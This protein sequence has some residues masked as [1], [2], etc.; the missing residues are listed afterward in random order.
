VFEGQYGYGYLNG[1]LDRFVNLPKMESSDLKT[2]YNEFNAGKKP[3]DVIANF[4]YHPEIVESE[5]GRFL[6]LSGI[7]IDALLKHII[8]DCGRILEPSGELK[9]LVDKYHKE[10][11]FRNEDIYELLSLK[12]Q[13][14]CQ[15]SLVIS[16]RVPV[17]L[18]PDNIVPL[19]C[20]QCKKS[21][22]GALINS[23]FELGTNILN[24]FAN[25]QCYHCRN[26]KAIEVQ[27]D[28]VI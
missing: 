6:R 10:G 5:Y 25:Y 27:G 9:R 21:I 3:V 7:D 24:Q 1:K 15:S 19:K 18:Y 8:A 2:L 11:N 20:S 17:E 23:K 28:A 26:P 4:G 13:H 22:P 14:E 12:S 16:I